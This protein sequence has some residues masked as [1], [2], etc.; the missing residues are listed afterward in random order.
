MSA[1]KF[2]PH[3]GKPVKPDYVFCE[4]CGKPLPVPPAPP[5]AISAPPPPPMPY[6]APAWYAA[7]RADF[8]SIFAGTFSTW[9]KNVVQYFGV[10]A[11]L[12]LVT[13]SLATLGAVLFLGVP[14]TPTGSGAINVTL[15]LTPASFGAYLAWIV[16]VAVIGLIAGSAILGGVTDFAVRRHRG[17]TPPLMESLRRGFGRFPSILGAN[18]VTTAITIGLILLPAAFMLIG[19]LSI[20]AMGPTGPPSSSILALLCGTSLLLPLTS[21]LA[22]YLTLSLLVNAPAIVME[23]TGAIGGLKR[24]WDLTKGH[25]W[26]LLWVVFVLGLI[27]AAAQLAFTPLMAAFPGPFVAIPVAVAIA[28]LTGSWSVVMA[29]VA[30]DLI[31]RERTSFAVPPTYVPSAPYHP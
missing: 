26:S 10:Y 29:A 5:A 14:Y 18:L 27:S 12:T 7:R 23:G 3:C 31:Q 15:I 19:L 30:Y 21:I 1:A 25:K 4:W 9:W 2:C 28:G 11:V 16:V 8:S 13:S 20:L 17:E 22:L 6:P 24:S